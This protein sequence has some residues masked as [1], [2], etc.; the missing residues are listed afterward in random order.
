MPP[1]DVLFLFTGVTINIV[2]VAVVDVSVIITIVITTANFNFLI[3][4]LFCNQLLQAV[5]L[6]IIP[7]CAIK[8]FQ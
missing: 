5:Q 8:I 4:S 1:L 6:L 7:L 3:I 2:V